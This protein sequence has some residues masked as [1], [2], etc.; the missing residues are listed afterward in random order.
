M[1]RGG[2]FM[3]P[4]RILVPLKG[5][6]QDEAVLSVIAPAAAAVGATLRLLHVAPVPQ[7]LYSERGRVVMYADQE[8]GRLEALW[9]TYLAGVSATLHDVATEC[10][11][12]FGRPADEIVAEAKAWG[13]E[14]IAMT[15][16]RSRRFGWLRLRRLTEV[17]SRKASIPVLGYKIT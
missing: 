7:N 4:K 2:R 6:A 13:A 14:L 5:S 1:Y 16:P 15:T 9:S 11:V 12:R 10:V 3:T 17:V 8:M